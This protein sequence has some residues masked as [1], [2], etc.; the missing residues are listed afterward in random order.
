MKASKEQRETQP[1]ASGNDKRSF[2]VMRRDSP[3]ISAIFS[4]EDDRWHLL[5][6]L[7]PYEK[8]FEATINFSNV[9]SWLRADAK[10]YV[11]HLWLT[12]CA[13]ANLIQ[14]ILGS[15][16]R[17]GEC[18]PKH[19]GTAIDLKPHQAKEFV[20]Q[21]CKL[22]LSPVSNQGVRRRINNFMS[23]VRQR[24][25]GIDNRFELVFPRDK[26]HLPNFEPL[27]QAESKR[28]SSQILAEIIDACVADLNAYLTEKKKFKHTD[29]LESVEK[30]R[31]YW[32]IK[33]RER[34]VRIKANIPKEQ[35]APRLVQL[36]GRAIKAQALILAICTGRRA[37][38]ICDTKLNVEAKK[39]G[40][41]NQAGQ[42]EEVVL[43]RFRERKIRNVDEDVPCPDAYGDL[44][45]NALKN[46][47]SLTAELRLHNP[48]LK[49]FLFL[50]PTKGHLHAT[51]LTPSQLNRYINGQSTRAKGLLARYKI[52]CQRITVHNFRATR[53]TNAWIGGL[54][55][56]EVAYDLGHT[57]A[58]MTL[59]HYV[60]GREEDRRR[61][62]ECID[63]G[64]LSGALE[65]LVGGREVIEMRLDRRHL[66]IMNKHGRV[67]T[68]N[69]YGYC[70]LP[71]TSGPCIRNVPCYIGP[72]VGL[73]GCDYHVLSP[74]ALPALEEDEEILMASISK[75]EQNP[76]YRVWVQHQRVQLDI[77]RT[78]IREAKTHSHRC[79]GICPDDGSCNCQNGEEKVSA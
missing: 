64:A 6:I 66:E 77:V 34:K 37:A 23:F 24:H 8:T 20:R 4:Y 3:S 10:A 17:L 75:F 39:V 50:I 78:K 43:V 26:T 73:G 59:R 12:G 47:K 44:V 18:F 25:P 56:H 62:Q 45:L 51:V 38:A 30:R 53:A 49:E 54:K 67:L 52:Q 28:I 40:W 65:D 22:G 61:L 63:K 41:V 16:R 13:R 31:E 15:L 1:I 74:D 76:A 42:R 70:S 46:A 11:A 36:L 69:R 58:D 55:I 57:N 32:R 48:E 19:R 21:Y 68:P 27:E 7:R 2:T 29:S 60:I 72:G 9:K 14:Q 71:A 79:A 5:D 33:A 35:W